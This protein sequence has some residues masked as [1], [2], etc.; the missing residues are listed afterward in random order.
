MDRWKVADRIAVLFGFA[1][2]PLLRYVSRNR[3]ALPHFQKFSDRAGFQVRSTHYYDPTYGEQSLPASTG[4]N[5]TLPGVDLNESG[6][7]A[8]LR[9][10]HYQDELRQI[11]RKKPSDREY[12]YENIMFAAGD[13]EIY[14]NII[15]LKKPRRIIEIGSGN[16]TLMAL[17][18]IA[19]NQK[20]G[21]DYECTVECVE[22]YEMNWLEST[23]VTVIRQRVEDV[24]LDFFGKL[25]KDDILFIDSSHVIRPFGDVL[26]EFQEI[27]PS[28]KPGVLIHVHDVF[29]PRDYPELWLRQQ[30]RLWNEQYLLECFLYQNHTVEVTCAVNWLKNNH[31][32]AFSAVCPMVSHDDDPGSFWMRVRD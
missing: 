5:R 29:T 28:L 4:H 20:E 25:E 30:R 18:A 14:Y 2:T 1:L 22:P 8:L 13:A 32:D 15:R 3:M 12:G 7:L 21:A 26:R 31:W 16:S 6:Q 11:P 10:F 27:I 9:Q 17:R 24:D 19:A 23:G